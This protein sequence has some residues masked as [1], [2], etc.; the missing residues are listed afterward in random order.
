MES[1]LCFIN[2]KLIKLHAKYA[3]YVTNDGT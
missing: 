2:E 3:H 1:A